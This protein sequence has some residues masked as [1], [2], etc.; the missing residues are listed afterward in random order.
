MKIFE[1]SRLLVH[2]AAQHGWTN[3]GYVPRDPAAT[4]MHTGYHLIEI[5]IEPPPDFWPDSRHCWFHGE[6]ECIDHTSTQRPPFSCGGLVAVEN[7][8]HSRR[9]LRG[10]R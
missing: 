9:Q 10:G 8:Y 6:F 7:D 3:R 2:L 5:G 4:R 1:P